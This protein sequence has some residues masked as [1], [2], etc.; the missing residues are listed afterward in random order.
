MT[1]VSLIKILQ[2]KDN[3][4]SRFLRGANNSSGRGSKSGA[5]RQ[6]SRGASGAHYNASGTLASVFSRIK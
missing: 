1:F 2:G 4:E 6:L 3:S 5:D